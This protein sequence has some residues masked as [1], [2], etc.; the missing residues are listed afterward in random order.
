MSYAMGT[1]SSVSVV[2]QQQAGYPKKHGSTPGR[3][4]MYIYS[5]VHPDWL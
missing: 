3:D 4:K 2:T 1:D 5:P